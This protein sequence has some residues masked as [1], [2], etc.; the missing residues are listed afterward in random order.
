MSARNLEIARIF[1]QIADLLEIAQ[2]STF[3]VNAYR[4]GSRA[5][6]SLA[7]DVETI[8]A[9]GELRKIGGIGE[10]L[11]EKIEEYLRTGAIGY[12]DEL[13]KT[14]PP[15]LTELMTIPEI[16]PK[17]A[18][19]LYQRLGVAN[20]DALERAAR[21]GK[22]RELPRLGTKIEQNILQGIERRR[23]ADVRQPIGVVLPQAQ[24]VCDS[25]RRVL[26]A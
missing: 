7:E 20:I 14:L 16:G 6:E 21:A 2:E 1:A 18:L 5:L 3:R 13:R 15:G 10:R 11:A 23:L 12:F 24:A 9:R 26:G 22:V 8:A 17:T 19:L 4:K 25:L